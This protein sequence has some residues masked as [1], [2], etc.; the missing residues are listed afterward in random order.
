MYQIHLNQKRDTKQGTCTHDP[1]HAVLERTKTQKPSM[2]KVV[3]LNDDFTPMDFV[4]EILKT[5]FNKDHQRAIEIM[6]SIHHQGSAICGTYSLEIAE[7]KAKR[8]MLMAKKA[9]HP[10]QCIAEKE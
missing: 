3:L 4:V 7:M 6:L 8:V 10:L 2:Y 1:G 9:G 5:V